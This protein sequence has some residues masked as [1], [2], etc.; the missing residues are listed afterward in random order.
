MAMVD[1]TRFVRLE[2]EEYTYKFLVDGRLKKDPYN[3]RI[4]PDSCGGESSLLVV[5]PIK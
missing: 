5:K 1:S 2:P 3:L 4:T